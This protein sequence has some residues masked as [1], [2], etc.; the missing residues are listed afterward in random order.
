MKIPSVLLAWWRH[1]IF[2]SILCLMGLFVAEWAIPGSVL[3]FF[4]PYPF[5][6]LLLVLAG[7]IPAQTEPAKGLHRTFTWIILTLVMAAGLLLVSLRT[8]LSTNQRLLLLGAVATGSLAFM[9]FVEANA[10][11]PTTTL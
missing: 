4:V 1:A 2:A 6:A 8:N 7:C 3:P 5:I 10:K 9:L 11:K